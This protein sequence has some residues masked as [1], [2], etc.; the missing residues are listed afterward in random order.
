M[1]VPGHTGIEGNEIA[2]L[3]IKTLK[4]ILLA[5]NHSSGSMASNTKES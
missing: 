1:Y 5:R 2:D 3:P 4:P